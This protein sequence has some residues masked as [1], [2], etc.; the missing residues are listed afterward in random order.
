[1]LNHPT[2]EK[3]KAMRL[4]GMVSA[5]EDQQKTPD[6]GSLSFE[7]RLGLLVDRE[8]TERDSR[9]LKTRL[10]KAKLKQ[11]ACIEDV[12][13]SGNRG[14]DKSQLLELASCQWIKGAHNLLVCGPTGVG[15]TFIACAMA[16]KACR[17]GLT[18]VYYRLPRLMG[19]LMIAKGDGR[20]SRLL[21]NLS[22]VDLI[23]LDDWGI[24]PLSADNRRDLLEILDDRYERKSTLITSQLPVDK[25]HRYLE[26][27]TLADAILDRVV[28]NAYRIELKGESMRKRKKKP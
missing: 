3:L 18:A 14:L 27:P 17:E 21:L 20:Y 11:Q 16:Q 7:E 9:R 12:D 26:D 5:F 15:K 25:W 24:A 8:Q 22:K 19:D 4:M 6:I 28:H 1:V 23:V 2:I 13:Y 10:T